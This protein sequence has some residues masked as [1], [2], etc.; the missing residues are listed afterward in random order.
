[1]KKIFIIPASALLLIL[2]LVLVAD[3]IILP[4]YVASDEV[5]VPDLVGKNKDEAVEILQN[6]GLNPIVEEP[7]F[8]ERYKKNDVIYHNPRSG[9][10]VKTNR[11]V[12]LFIS[13]GE[14]QI[15]MPKLIGKTLRDANVTV[16]RLGLSLGD[17]EETRSEFP[18]NTIIE[19][20]FDEGE[21]LPKG[22]IIN[23]KIS[24]GPQVGMIRVP[25]LLGKSVK[26]AENILHRHSLKF[27]QKVYLSSP[28]LLPNTII[29]QYPSE[30]KLLSYGD[31]V[32]VTITQS[33]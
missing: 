15:R 13:G 30:D 33:N 21:I 6:I 3:N 4:W 27:G 11:R 28:N 1:M 23:L 2:I 9:I 17:L 16:E 32:D 25:S 5:T 14:P 24:V 29:D 22:T 7:R 26:E 20:E 12:Y 18:A 19:Q 31:S 8:D 10:N